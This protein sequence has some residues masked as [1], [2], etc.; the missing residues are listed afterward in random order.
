MSILM[1]LPLV[2]QEYLLGWGILIF[3]GLA[4]INFL[5]QI[6]VSKKR[7]EERTARGIK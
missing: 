7:Y 1:I 6:Y 5:V 2:V 4:V 3:F